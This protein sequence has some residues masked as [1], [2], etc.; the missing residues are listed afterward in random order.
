[1]DSLN[2]M[3]TKLPELVKEK[4]FWFTWKRRIDRVC[5][6][7]HEIFILPIPDHEDESCGVWLYQ[8]DDKI[9]F[10]GWSIFNYRHWN[11]YRP[12]FWDQPLTKIWHFSYNLAK[13]TRCSGKTPTKYELPKK[14]FFSSGDW[15]NFD[16]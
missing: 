11:N 16:K 3:R 13:Q 6:E 15:K 2:L 8:W 10:S 5:Q 4:I 9:R 14:Y 7:Y 1:M 12:C